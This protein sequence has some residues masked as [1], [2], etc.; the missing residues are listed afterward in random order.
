MVKRTVTAASAMFV[1]VD[2][3]V[4]VTGTTEELSSN[5]S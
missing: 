1:L 2:C 5:D 4:K 3:C